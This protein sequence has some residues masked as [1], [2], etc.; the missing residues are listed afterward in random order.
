MLR[1]L[2]N[3]LLDKQVVYDQTFFQQGW[4]KEW[5]KLKYVLAALIESEPSWRSILDFGCGPGVMIDMMGDRG[6]DYIGC[7]YSLGARRLYISNYGKYSERYV[8]TIDECLRKNRDLLLAFD[9]LEHMLDEEIS[10][11]LEKTST[12]PEVLLNISRKRGIPGHINIKSDQA[13]I[14]FLNSHGLHFEKERTYALRSVYAQMRPGS[15]DLWD[16]NL[17]LFRREPA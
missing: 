12:I 15:P 9:V 5:E 16:R 2:W 13:W 7:D 3:R 10:Q 11:L 17:F 8:S 4:F 6:F 1:N 14:T